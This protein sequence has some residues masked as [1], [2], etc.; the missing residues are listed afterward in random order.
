MPR[1]PAQQVLIRIDFCESFVAP[2]LSPD[3]RFLAILDID[4]D[5]AIWDTSN[6]DAVSVLLRNTR[7]IAP[8][9]AITLTVDAAFVAVAVENVVE[10]WVRRAGRESRKLNL[11]TPSDTTV[12]AFSA[13]K[14][15][16]AAGTEEGHIYLWAVPSGKLLHT[17]RVRP[18]SDGDDESVIALQFLSAPSHKEPALIAVARSGAV[19]RLRYL[20]ESP[21]QRGSARLPRNAT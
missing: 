10:L 21:A 14:H 2:A 16:L 15:L 20:T 6:G 17:W 8:V 7:L 9:R 4:G 11:E 13:D 3:G 1:S 12:V 19:R 18:A 5:V